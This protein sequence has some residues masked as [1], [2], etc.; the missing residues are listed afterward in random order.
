MVFDARKATTTMRWVLDAM[1]QGEGEYSK[2]PFDPQHYHHELTIEYYRI[3]F[4]RE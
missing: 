4:D 1:T 3:F 2:I